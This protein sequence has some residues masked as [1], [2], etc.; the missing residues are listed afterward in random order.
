[1]GIPHLYPAYAIMRQMLSRPTV[2][3]V[4]EWHFSHTAVVEDLS[5]ISGLLSSNA[6]AVCPQYLEVTD[7]LSS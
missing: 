1:M 5:C 7:L 6:A 2:G 4:G 3:V